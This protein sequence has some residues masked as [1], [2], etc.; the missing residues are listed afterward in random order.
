[1]SLG[2]YV[3]ADRQLKIDCPKSSQCDIDFFHCYLTAKNR[4]FYAY[5]NKKEM[6]DFHGTVSFD[7]VK[8]SQ[9]KKK[10]KNVY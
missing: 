3:S 10:K 6:F 4:H 5:S 9:Q 8:M 1:M 2:L 7:P